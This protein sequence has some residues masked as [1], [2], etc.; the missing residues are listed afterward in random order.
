M[1]YVYPS[2]TSMAYRFQ[3]DGEGEYPGRFLSPES[4][5]NFTDREHEFRF[6]WAP[7][8][9]P[10]CGPRSRTWTAMT[11]WGRATFPA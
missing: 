7:S 4:A 3:E 10:R 11:A 8:A 5:G 2:G 1:R 9:R 6:D